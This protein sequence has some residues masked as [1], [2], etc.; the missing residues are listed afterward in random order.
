MAYLSEIIVGGVTYGFEDEVARA[1]KPTTASVTLTSAGWTGS[2]P[3]TQTA[4]IDGATAQSKVDLQPDETVLAQMLD[5][6]VSALFCK[7][8]NGTLTVYALGAAPSAD[9]TVQVTL[10]EV[11]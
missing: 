1:M 11:N 3:Y 5:D 6:G 8:D 2:D 10:T 4:S 7:N 9:M